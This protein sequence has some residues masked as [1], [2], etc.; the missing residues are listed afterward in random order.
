MKPRL[1]EDRAERL[2]QLYPLGAIP[3]QDWPKILGYKA[4]YAAAL[5]AVGKGP[6]FYKRGKIAM[7]PINPLLDWL[8]EKEVMPCGTEDESA[9]AGI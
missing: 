7:Y 6:P 4:S 1:R 8:E 5:A 9:E 3:R 2:F